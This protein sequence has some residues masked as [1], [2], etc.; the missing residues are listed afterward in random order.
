M[1]NESVPAK[2]LR[3]SP[4]SKHAP[5]PRSGGD[6]QEQHRS[7]LPDTE[8]S[9]SSPSRSSMSAGTCEESDVVTEQRSDSHIRTESGSKPGLR[10]SAAPWTP[11]KLVSQS[12]ALQPSQT[13][14][15]L[16]GPSIFGSTNMFAATDHRSSESLDAVF[17]APPSQVGS[18]NGMITAKTSSE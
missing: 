3:F 5:L 6:K 10:A 1:D 15:S 17:G 16:Y 13:W 14:Q 4:E 2:R 7:S 8:A 18:A 9:A 11:A 12:N